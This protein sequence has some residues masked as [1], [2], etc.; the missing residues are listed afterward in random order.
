VLALLQASKEAT[1]KVKK[2]SSSKVHGE[3]SVVTSFTG[4]SFRDFVF[5]RLCGNSSSKWPQSLVVPLLTTIRDLHPDDKELKMAVR[6]H[7]VVPAPGCV[8]WIWKTAGMHGVQAPPR[9]LTPQLARSPGHRGA[10][11]QHLGPT[12]HCAPTPRCCVLFR[13]AKCSASQYSWSCRSFL[14]SSTSSCF[15][16][17]MASV[18]QF[19]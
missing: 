6:P 7:D 9:G 10:F 12:S 18:R 11:Q 8:R 5:G 3:G 2:M 16:P 13:C 1:L 4:S 19:W 17:H 14:L 15:F